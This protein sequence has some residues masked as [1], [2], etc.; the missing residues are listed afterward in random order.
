VLQDEM[1]TFEL[2]GEFSPEISSDLSSITGSEFRQRLGP[3][4]TSEPFDLSDAVERQEASK[5]VDVAG[6]LG[7]K[8][9]A[10]SG[11]AFGVL[12]LRRGD[13]HTAADAVVPQQVSF[14]S[15]DNGLNIDAVGFSAAAPE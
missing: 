14:K 15:Q 10:L 2:A 11:E 4:A 6:L 1:K 9:G 8:S 12:L 3:V 13:D 7:R 5:P